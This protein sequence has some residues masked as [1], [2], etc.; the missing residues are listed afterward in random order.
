MKWMFALTLTGMLLAGITQAGDWPQIL[1]P[2]RS[3][4]ASDE[5]LASTW[6]AGGPKVVWEQ[7]VGDGFS[8]IAIAEGIAIVY[9]RAGQHD[10]VEA[11]A[12]AT[13]KPL[14]RKEFPT[15]YRSG[16]STDQGPRATPVIHGDSVYLYSAQ[17]ALRRL[18][19]K[20]G[21]VLWAVETHQ[22][23]DA[24]EGY[25][26]AGSTPI[27]VEDKI[28]V[29]VGGE[30]A[31]SGIVAF[32]LKSGEEVWKSTDD[33]ASYSSPILVDLEGRKILIVIARL[34]CFALDPASGEVLGQLRFGSRGPTVNGASPVLIGKDHIFLTASY[35]VGSTYTQ[36]GTTG[37]KPFYENEALIYSQYTTPIEHDGALYAIDGR[38]DQGVADLKCIAP[39]T[40]Q[41]HWTKE[42]FGYATLI[43]AADKLILLTT[44]G[45]LVLAQP[46]TAEY[47]E[48]ARA[49]VLASTTRALPALAGGLLYIRDESILKCLD[50]RAQ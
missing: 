14:W 26:G 16:I 42:G 38:D 12:A 49:T 32:S 28:I 4:H 5:K 34:T 29:N 25:F 44:S 11:L 33:A 50:L 21:N 45:E 19:L 8:G 37:F 30:K 2:Q 35:G 13:G 27:I 43:A 31:S 40:R 9:H 39:A 1:G 17:G 46:S 36:L 6:P 7:A 18:A 22:L 24:P 15:T 41:V 47:K 3:G 48:L 10:R 23:Y 20:D